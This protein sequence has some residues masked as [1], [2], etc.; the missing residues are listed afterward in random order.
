MQFRARNII[1]PYTS[2]R[3][4]DWPDFA[5]IKA[6]GAGVYWVTD[7]ESFVGVGYNTKKLPADQVPRNYDDLLNPALKGSSS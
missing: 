6:K 3:H 5:Q 4:K 1:R 2:P 7:R